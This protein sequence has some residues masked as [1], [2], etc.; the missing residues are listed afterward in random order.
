MIEVSLIPEA[1]DW[2]PPEELLEVIKAFLDVLTVFAFMMLLTNS[3]GSPPK[4]F[5]MSYGNLFVYHC[6]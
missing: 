6:S 2:H 1:M 5:M 3:F 4:N